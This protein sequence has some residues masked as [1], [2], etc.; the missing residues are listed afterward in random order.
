[1]RFIFRAESAAIPLLL[2]ALCLSGCA[3]YSD[4]P[5]WQRQMA[6]G[7][8]IDSLAPDNLLHRA[9]QATVD[10]G[11]PAAR[12]LLFRELGELDRS[13]GLLDERL[14]RAT[15]DRSLVYGDSLA[16]LG[17]G[18]RSRMVFL[19]VPGMQRDPDNP[20]TSKELLQKAKAECERNGFEARLVKTVPDGTASTNAAMFA[21]EFEEVLGQNENVV[22][23][24]TSKGATD[25]IRYLHREGRALPADLRANLKVILSLAGPL[26]GSVMAHWAAT[27]PRPAP[28]LSRLALGMSSRAHLLQAVRDMGTSE[29]VPGR[30]GWLSETYPN[31]TWIS[32]VMLPAGEDGR[33][34]EMPYWPAGLLERVYH[35]SRVYSPNDGLVESG[36]EVL[37]PDTGVPQWIIRGLGSHAIPMSRYADGTRIAPNTQGDN[38]T[39]IDPRSGGEMFSALLR[40][41]PRSVLSK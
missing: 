32:F 29:W 17:P 23:V 39:T 7:A 19:L 9:R 16:A 18:E 31:L 40:A 38:V 11:L 15:R 12:D 41:L 26:Q 28:V 25:L 13:H 8:G 24:T 20:H 14:P 5:V 3:I 30:N 2:A 10:K 1:M 21:P 22:V 37:P 33:V 34:E 4:P 36:A 35:T 27:S 6:R